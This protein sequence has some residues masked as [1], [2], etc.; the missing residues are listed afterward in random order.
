M[1]PVLPR[2]ID[3]APDAAAYRAA[4]DGL[5][6]S[7][8]PV[9]DH[10]RGTL[11]VPSATLE[12]RWRTMIDALPSGVTHMALHATTP[13]DFADIAPDHAEWRFAEYALLGGGAVKTML[14]QADIAVIGCREIQT[15]WREGST[16]F[17]PSPTPISGS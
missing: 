14:E 3:W 6:R 13:G 4:V 11:A 5:D 8:R 9:A 7:G 16:P 1:W 2:S 10:C 17:N 12:G 15:L